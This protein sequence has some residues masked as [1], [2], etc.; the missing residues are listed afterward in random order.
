MDASQ[1]QFLR[2]FTPFVYYL[3]S[4]SIAQNRE[5]TSASHIKKDI[6]WKHRKSNN[7][8]DRR[9]PV[10]DRYQALPLCDLTQESTLLLSPTSPCS[11][12]KCRRR[13]YARVKM[14]SQCAEEPEGG[15]SGGN[16]SRSSTLG[17]GHRMVFDVGMR[18]R[19]E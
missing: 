12:F 10:T 3:P 7:T 19:R 2:A 11:A 4:L 13:S 15:V 14:C 5:N 1:T 17:Y 8:A 18:V 16:N 6:K 9:S